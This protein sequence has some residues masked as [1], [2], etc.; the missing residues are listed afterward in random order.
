MKNANYYLSKMYG[1]DYMIPPV[2]DKREVHCVMELDLG[3]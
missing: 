2:E 3:E 1:D